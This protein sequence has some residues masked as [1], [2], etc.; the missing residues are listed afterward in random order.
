MVCGEVLNCLGAFI[1]Q[2]NS[3][4]HQ[5]I[6]HV[7]LDSLVAKGVQPLQHHPSPLCINI[8]VPIINAICEK[9]GG[10]NGWVQVDKTYLFNQSQ[11]KY[12]CETIEVHNLFQNP[13][14]NS[15]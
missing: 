11:I 2:M 4:Q 9:W 12:P 14:T 15:F 13:P 5:N 6:F 7:V 10:L 1:S 3:F 8:I